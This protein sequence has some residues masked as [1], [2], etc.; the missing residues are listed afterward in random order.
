MKTVLLL[1]LMT[2]SLSSYC[3][4][5]ITGDTLTYSIESVES[6]FRSD[7]EISLDLDC[8][9]LEDLNISSA[10]PIDQSWPWERLS[11]K[12]ADGVEVC[13]S[14]IGL[15]STF[16]VGDTLSFTDSHWTPSLDFIY[17]TGKAGSYGQYQTKKKY[18]AFRKRLDSATIYS[19]IQ[20]SNQGIDFSIHQIISNCSKNI[21]KIL[22]KDSPIKVF[23]NPSQGRTQ[24]SSRVEKLSIYDLSGNLIEKYHAYPQDI[25][26]RYL[27]PGIYILK[28]Q[29]GNKEEL[30]KFIRE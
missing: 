13:N 5:W 2:S 19:F 15:V 7:T 3:Q 30:V 4:Y 12:M 27:A 8:D 17:G 24:L 18:I 6:S 20:F 10:Q 22:T 16:G 26:L 29:R 1:L 23:P 9:G 28:A 14:G 25:D 11:F 21:L